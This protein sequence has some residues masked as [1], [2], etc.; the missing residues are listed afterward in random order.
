MHISIRHPARQVDAGR[1]TFSCVWIVL[2]G[3]SSF[4]APRKQCDCFTSQHDRARHCCCWRM[5]TASANQVHW[6]AYAHSST[7][8][9]NEAQVWWE[10]YSDLAMRQIEIVFNSATA[11]RPHRLYPVY[12]SASR[13]DLCG[14]T[15]WSGSRI[16]CGPR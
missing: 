14:W 3:N 2:H 1:G 12:I 13:T 7:L 9:S 5:L 6:T 15:P 10:T 11:R 8:Q 4:S 16:I